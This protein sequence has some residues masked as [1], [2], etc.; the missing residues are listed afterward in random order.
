[1]ADIILETRAR[2]VRVL[3]ASGPHDQTDDQGNMT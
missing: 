2:R 3:A 1:M